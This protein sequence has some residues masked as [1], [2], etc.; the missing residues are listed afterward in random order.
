MGIGITWEA[1][2]PVDVVK[3][4]D[5]SRNAR[6]EL[7]TKAS[8]TNPQSASAHAN[9]ERCTNRKNRTLGVCHPSCSTALA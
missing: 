4:S 5:S 2:P 9:S 1:N 7:G 3:F 8:E 6:A